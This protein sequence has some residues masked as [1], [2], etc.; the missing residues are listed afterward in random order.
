MVPARECGEDR[1]DRSGEPSERIL[2]G[3]SN[4]PMALALEEPIAATAFCPSV[5]PTCNL[6][7]GRRDDELV[8]E[9]TDSDGLPGR[10]RVCGS[11]A[12]LVFKGDDGIWDI[13]R[14]AEARL[15]DDPDALM[16]A[17]LRRR[18]SNGAPPGPWS[19]LDARLILG[20]PIFGDRSD[21]STVDLRDE[22][23]TRDERGVGSGALALR[24]TVCGT[25]PSF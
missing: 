15:D 1:P 24:N 5:L 21:G 25:T 2:D 4:R 13:G 9:T 23:V 20:V 22:V 6:C 17:N 14:A 10:S 11:P 7:I 18:S 8:F 3:A 19:M 12:E 16:V